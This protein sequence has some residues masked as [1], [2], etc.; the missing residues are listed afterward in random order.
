MPRSVLHEFSD[1]VAPVPVT[2]TVTPAP[3]RLSVGRTES[4][5]FGRAATVEK[6]D[7]R[8]KKVNAERV[9]VQ[10]MLDAQ[11]AAL[12]KF[13]KDE[14]EAKRK[15]DLLYGHFDVVQ[16]V[17]K[18]L[19][20]AGKGVGWKTVQEKLKE[21][22]AVG[23]PEA[24]LV[25]SLNPNDGTAVLVLDDTTGPPGRGKVSGISREC[26]LPREAPG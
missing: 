11:D 3:T 13:E 19:W 12:K 23:N 20:D 2:D 8:L 18:T 15:A 10:R 6:V 22:R 17:A 7:P 5:C 25:E 16:R 26:T 21:G 14:I 1:H 4:I 24:L 9:K